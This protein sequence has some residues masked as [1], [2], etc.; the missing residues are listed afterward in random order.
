M[1]RFY[2]FWLDCS[3]YIYMYNHTWI[4]SGYWWVYHG[5]VVGCSVEPTIWSYMIYM[6]LSVAPSLPMGIQTG[7][8]L[9]KHG[10]MN[11]PSLG[12]GFSWCKYC[13]DIGQLTASSTMVS[14]GLK[15][16]WMQT[17]YGTS[18]WWTDAPPISET[19]IPWFGE[20]RRNSDKLQHQ[21]WTL[22]K[23]DQRQLYSWGCIRVSKWIM[24]VF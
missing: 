6:I 24:L 5:N 21:I 13:V 11:P 2:H 18:A 3:M 9:C 12:R 1:E 10:M 15:T 22:H 16:Q 4:Y 8:G 20:V 17:I 7:N 14:F 19:V 23:G